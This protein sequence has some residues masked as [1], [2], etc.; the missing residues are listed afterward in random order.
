[1]RPLFRRSVLAPEVIQTSSIDCGPAALSSLLGGF[2]IQASFGRLRESCQTTLDGTSIDAIEN[3]A[4]QLGLDAEQVIVPIDHLRLPQSKV[5]PAIGVTDTPNGTMHFVV[6]WQRFG[7]WVQVMDPACGRRWMTM[8]ALARQLHIHTMAIPADTWRQWASGKSNVDALR[9]RAELL[10]IR[11]RQVARFLRDALADPTWRTLAI[12]DAAIRMVA[13]LVESDSIAR[14]RE[15]HRLLDTLVR[16]ALQDGLDPTIPNPFRSAQPLPGDDNMLLVTGAVLLVAR[17]RRSPA[18]RFERSQSDSR[19]ILSEDAPKPLRKL[20]STVLAEGA[21][22]PTALAVMLVVAAALV[23][24]EALLM[25]GM[26]D[27]AE[28]LSLSMQRLAAITGLVG[29]FAA[30]VLLDLPIQAE[31]LRLGRAL[32]LRLRVAFLTKVRTLGLTYFQSRPTSDMAERCHRL[33]TLRQFPPAVAQSIRALSIMTATVLGLLWLAPSAKF[34]VLPLL[35]LALLAPMILQPI[36]N[37]RDVRFRT[38]A[39]ALTRFYLDALLGITPIRSHSA[40]RAVRVEHESMLVEWWRTGHQLLRANLWIS[41]VQ[42]TIATVLGLALMAHYL[43][44]EGEQ[45]H[46]LL[47]TFWAMSLPTLAQGFVK[48]LQVFPALRSSSLRLLDPLGAPDDVA[49]PAGTKP[50]ARASGV[51]ISMRS[52]QAHA[53]GRLILDGINLDIAAG[54]HVAIVGP[55]GSGKSSL[56]GLL[57]GWRPHSEGSLRVDGADLDALRLREQT[58]WLDP[59]LQL[60]NE[61]L[62]DNIVYGARH[63]SPNMRDVLATSD[64]RGFAERLSEGMQTRLGENGAL[65]SGGE[66]QRIRF[67][68]T[69]MRPDARLVI[70]DEPFRGLD[71]VARR[72]CLDRARAVWSGATFLC[73]THDV[74]ETQAFPSVIVIED[75]RIVEHDAPTRLAADPSSR[76]RAMLDAEEELTDELWNHPSWKRW[77]VSNGAIDTHQHPVIEETAEAA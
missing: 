6:I 18:G 76:Y 70:F 52:V 43:L 11:G 47:L 54:E 20:V 19:A 46:L 16:R 28:T 44:F 41:G 21:S 7:E 3:I 56:V 25:R 50:M 10:G 17:G 26:L 72:Q 62:F 23:M 58:A 5:L 8:S 32:E 38:Q 65:A 77:R 59:T 31:L 60:W 49:A 68:R 57:L 64:V 12:L 9:A 27:L 15:A 40:T 42:A 13:N 73:V 45:S 55:S 34:L 48:S 39:G 33:H 74:R 1:M 22:R 61:T 24:V 35:A 2:G 30:L 36:L 69:L 4:C 67:A 71:R 37:E 66:G 14:G 29:F 75:G 51:T 63:G 53:G